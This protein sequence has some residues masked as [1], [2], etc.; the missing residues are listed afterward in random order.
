ME[1]K[2]LKASTKK[3]IYEWKKEVKVNDPFGDFDLRFLLLLIVQIKFLNTLFTIDQ[4][5][6][7]QHRFLDLEMDIN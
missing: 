1:Q 2:Y 4:E 3:K 5:F 7:D 6:M